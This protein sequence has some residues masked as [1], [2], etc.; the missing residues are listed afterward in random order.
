MVNH[1]KLNRRQFLRTASTA[2]FSGLMLNNLSAVAGER[3]TTIKHPLIADPDGLLDLPEGFTYQIIS[4]LGD[5]MSDGMHVPDAADGMGCLALDDDRVVLVRNHELTPQEIMAQPDSIVSHHSTQAYDSFADGTSLP[6]GT[7]SLVY[8]LGKGK[9]ESEFVSLSG[10]IRNCAGGITP[11]N[12]WL[13]CEEDVTRS[14]DRLQPSEQTKTA[15]KNG[16]TARQDHGYVFEVPASARGPVKPVPLKAMGRFNHEA[17]AVDPRTGIVYM[18][19]DRGDS[20]FYRFIPHTAGKLAEG[21]RLQALVLIEQNQF[22]TRNWQQTGM[23][24]QR[25]YATRWIDLD[26]PQAPA[27][28]LRL[29]GYASGAAVFARGEGI[30]WGANELY[31][32]CTNGGAKQLGQVMRYQ[33]SAAEG[34][35]GEKSAPGR[36]QLFAESTSAAMY[37]YGDNLTVT[38]FGHLLVCEDQ[39]TQVVNNQLRG[40][41]PDGRIYSFARLRAQTELAGACFSPDG[42]TLFVNIYSPAKTLAITGD[43][44]KIKA[45]EV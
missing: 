23:P 32:C 8:H 30:H 7:T 13:T 1:M 38:P 19:E 33:P 18:T 6:G 12:T 40:I 22:D 36:I 5:A 11:W 3:T 16:D 39:Y 20:L 35:A 44:E 28:D 45:L 43:W 25:W 27:D 15:T 10:T 41:T 9:V 34:Q 26:D 2:A 21:G 31:F 29:R 17:A 24:L 4:Q 42:S 14:G 37:N